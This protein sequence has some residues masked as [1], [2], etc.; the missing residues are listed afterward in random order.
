MEQDR[1]GHSPHAP[2]LD[3]SLDRLHRQRE[4]GQRHRRAE[5]VDPDRDRDARENRERQRAPASTRRARSARG[6]M[7]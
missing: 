5:R 6:A 3:L 2:G 4:A 1:G 7:P